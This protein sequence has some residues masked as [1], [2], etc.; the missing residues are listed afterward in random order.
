MEIVRSVFGVAGPCPSWYAGRFWLLRIGYYKLMRPKEQTGDWVWIVDHTV[1]LG[2]EKCLLILGV[3]LSQLSP[4]DLVLSHD[5]VEPIALFPV[6]H[7][8]GEVVFEQ[9]EYAETYPHFW[10][11]GILDDLLGQAIEKVEL[12]VLE[13]KAALDEAAEA[14]KEE[15]AK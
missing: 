6:T 13:P 5:D 1:Q 10:E 9:L 8:R 4:T 12:G 11:M 15:M 2:A 14:L 7:S 3:R